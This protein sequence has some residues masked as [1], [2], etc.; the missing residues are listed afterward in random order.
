MELATSYQPIYNAF[1]RHASVISQSESITKRSTSITQNRMFFARLRCMCYMGIWW[2]SPILH[3]RRCDGCAVDLWGISKTDASSH[4][5][6][7]HSCNG[8]RYSVDAPLRQL[9]RKPFGEPFCFNF[10]NKGP[11][12]YVW[13]YHYKNLSPLYRY[14]IDY[15][16]ND[17]VL[18]DEPNPSAGYTNRTLLGFALHWLCFRTTR[19]LSDDYLL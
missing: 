17:E 2:V 10:L 11:V 9:C 16:L 6:L 5:P 13:R 15:P 3:R 8:R 19:F 12:G 14:S 18:S 7:Y 4:R 1:A